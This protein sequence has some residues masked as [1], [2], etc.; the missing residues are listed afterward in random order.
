MPRILNSS[1]Y[2]S[3]NDIING[4]LCL[5]EN[6]PR[7]HQIVSNKRSKIKIS[8][9][10]PIPLVC[11]MF[12]T[13]IRTCLPPPQQSMQSHFVPPPPNP[14]G[15]KAERNPVVTVF[16]SFA[17]CDLLIHSDILC[18]VRARSST[19]VLSQSWG[20]ITEIRTANESSLHILVWTFCLLLE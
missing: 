18:Y 3:C 13:W 4:K 5:C 9:G 12:C 14:L 20:W 16:F 15:Q 19:V 8:R 1:L 6:S 7:F 11:H 2:K 17:V 10:P